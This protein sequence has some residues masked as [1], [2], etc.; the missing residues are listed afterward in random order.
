M[1]NA[2]LPT[3][4]L[5]GG[6]VTLHHMPADD[7]RV[8]DIIVYDGTTIVRALDRSKREGGQR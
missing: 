4:P 7:L 2:R 6:T 1:P 8:G 3:M 5:P